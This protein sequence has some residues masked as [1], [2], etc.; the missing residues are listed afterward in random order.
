MPDGFPALPRVDIVR[1]TVLKLIKFQM[2]FSLGE[3][4]GFP[5]TYVDTYK[6]SCVNP[7]FLYTSKKN[8]PPKLSFLKKKNFKTKN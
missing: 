7:A 5:F 1:K 4:A 8:E 3:L 6:A 2:F